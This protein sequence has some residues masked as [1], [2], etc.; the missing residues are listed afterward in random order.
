[1]LTERRAEIKNHLEQLPWKKDPP[2]AS[3]PPD[4]A[5]DKLEAVF[6]GL[7]GA[8]PPPSRLMPAVPRARARRERPDIISIGLLLLIVVVLVVGVLVIL[9]MAQS[10][11]TMIPTMTPT[12]LPTLKP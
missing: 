10:G 3:T 5:E 2:K 6:Y 7:L 4:P 12:N 11:P 9:S 1:M 8:A